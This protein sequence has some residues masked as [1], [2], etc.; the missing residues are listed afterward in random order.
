MGDI[1]PASAHGTLTTGTACLAQGAG[2]DQTGHASR[3]T[4]PDSTG[5]TAGLHGCRSGT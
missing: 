3:R 4:E 1:E 2:V 5:G